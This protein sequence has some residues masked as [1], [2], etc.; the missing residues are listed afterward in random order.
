MKIK[1]PFWNL[2]INL[3]VSIIIH[4]LS[5]FQLHAQE[6]SSFGWSNYDGQSE[7]G[8]VTG[9]GTATSIEVTTF[10]ALKAAVE[11]SDSH[12]I[13]IMN[14]MGNGY[15]GTSGDV[16]KF[17]SNKTIVGMKPGI[18]V[19]CSFQI[20]KANNIIVRNLT[21]RG[22]GNSN[23][24]QNW[25]A[26]SIQGSQKI[27]FD[28]CTIMEGEDGNFDVVKGSDNVTVSWCKFTYITNGEHNLSN[29]IGSSD[30]ESISHGKL[31][32]TFAYCWWDNINSRCPRTRYG[33]IHVLNCYYNNVADAA[34]SGFMSNLR[35]EGC[36]FESNVKNPTGLISSGGQSGVFVIDCNRGETKTDGYT[37]VFTPPYTY[38]KYVTSEV[39]SIITN[40][41]NGAGSTLSSTAD[42]GLITGATS[43]LHKNNPDISPVQLVISNKIRVTLNF[44]QA[45]NAR[46]RLLDLN[47]RKVNTLTSISTGSGITKITLDLKS[48]QPGMYILNVNAGERSLV[49]KIIKN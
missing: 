16:L 46:V 22:P 36:F 11:S 6:C 49:Q 42:C 35:V 40:P 20:N 47:G 37:T 43:R 1:K 23:A 2:S 30:D 3:A 10:S 45:G 31:N 9:G 25:D 41:G 19:Q 15:T 21:I 8:A 32:V 44:K 48:I 28:H 14:D 5:P 27:W 34:F 39:K 13:L 24:Q 38:K 4:V 18:I 7:I 12:V 33:K 17:K 26:V 29:L